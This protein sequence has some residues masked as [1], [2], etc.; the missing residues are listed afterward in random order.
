MSISI[1]DLHDDKISI[2]EMLGS[3][4]QEY[5]PGLTCGAR[6]SSI[7]VPVSTSPTISI[8]YCN[9]LPEIGIVFHGYL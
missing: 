8:E 9:P 5:I 2:A 1:G 7:A 4:T 3:A 6:F